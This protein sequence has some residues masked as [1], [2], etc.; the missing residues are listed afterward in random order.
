[1]PL[2]L[3]TQELR[4]GLSTQLQYLPTRSHTKNQAVDNPIFD[5]FADNSV[6]I[7][8]GET[9]ASAVGLQTNNPGY[10]GYD[11]SGWLLG[12]SLFVKTAF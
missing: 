12:A 11:H 7:S 6:N 9:I 8:S 10:P 1:M 5:E 3:G 2:R 4:L